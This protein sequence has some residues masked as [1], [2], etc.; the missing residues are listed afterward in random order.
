MNFGIRNLLETMLVR[1]DHNQITRLKI[2][3]ARCLSAVALYR[4]LKD[5]NLAMTSK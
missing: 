3:S 5:W 1:M 4:E 2:W